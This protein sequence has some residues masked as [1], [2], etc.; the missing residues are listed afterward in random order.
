MVARALSGGDKLAEKL[1]EISARLDKA[2]V[3]RIGFLEGSTESLTGASSASVA[4]YQ[5]FGTVNT[6]SKTVTPARPFFRPMIAEH[7]KEWGDQLATILSKNG[8][9]TDNALAK[10]GELI[11]SELQDA[12]VA[13]TSPALSP[14]TLMLRKMRSEDQDLK[15]GGKTVA[16]AA[17]RVAAG[18]SPGDVSIKPLID[19]G[20]MLASV[21]YQVD[22]HEQVKVDPDRRS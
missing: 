11:G 18:E 12:I 2:A 15:V 22:D 19:T 14:I 16:E 10:M 20:D 4:T 21:A 7:S 8:Y 9:D 1:K 13:V 5:E 6:K 3:V 17:R